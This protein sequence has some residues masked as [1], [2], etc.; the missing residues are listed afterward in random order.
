M[1]SHSLKKTTI[2]ASVLN[3]DS[4]K[5]VW[6]MMLTHR[7]YNT[8][9][10]TFSRQPIAFESFNGMRG[11]IEIYTNFLKRRINFAIL[12]NTHRFDMIVWL[13][14]TLRAYLFDKAAPRSFSIF[15]KIS[16]FSVWNSFLFDVFL[17]NWKLVKVAVYFEKKKVNCS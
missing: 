15:N 7:S 14:W 16:E 9:Y 17:E 2:R 11:N 1:P 8:T 6:S 4:A 3:I 12:E 10:K 13:H 5:V